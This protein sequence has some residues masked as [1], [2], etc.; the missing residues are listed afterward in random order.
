[1]T[2]GFQRLSLRSLTSPAAADVLDEEASNQRWRPPEVAA[3]SAMAAAPLSSA[4]TAAVEHQAELDALREQARSEGFAQGE[5]EARQ[6]LAEQSQQLQLLMAALREPLQWLDERLQD[7]LIALA[8]ALAKAL[9]GR[10]LSQDPELLRDTVHA[11]V[12]LLPVTEGELEVV[13]NPADIQALRALSEAVGEPL[14]PG[15]KIIEEAD[16]SRGG[17]LIRTPVS[18][19]DRRL[20]SRLQSL[21]EQAQTAIEDGDV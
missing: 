21:L 15:W 9:L 1:M 6:M 2:D 18:Q 14:E 16:I 13:L 4:P 10:E 8:C 3:Q 11:A 17:C 12:E 19:I 5:A 7:E 20:E